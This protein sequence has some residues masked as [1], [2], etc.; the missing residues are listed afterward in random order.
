MVPTDII[1]IYLRLC[2]WRQSKFTLKSFTILI[3]YLLEESVFEKHVETF[4]VHG[5]QGTLIIFIWWWQ[6]RPI[7]RSQKFGGLLVASAAT[8]VCEV[9]AGIITNR[10]INMSHNL[11]WQLLRLV[12]SR[13]VSIVLRRWTC[14]GIILIVLLLS[15]NVRIDEAF[16][17]AVVEGLAKDFVE[18]L[19][20]ILLLHYVHQL[21]LQL[22]RE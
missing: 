14:H 11:K 3:K 13:H 21:M 17:D 2:Q 1:L 20:E 22:L 9:A 8:R 16:D 18:C 19:L 15:E 4:N 12:I 10:L 6:K 5:I 7:Q